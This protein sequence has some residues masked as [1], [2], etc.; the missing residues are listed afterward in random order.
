MIPV[1]LDAQV[2]YIVHALR[3]M[4][5]KGLAPIEPTRWAFDAWDAYTQRQAARSVVTTTS[6]YYT[7]KSGKVVTEWIG[8]STEYIAWSTA[9]SRLGRFVT[10]SRGRRQGRMSRVSP[11]HDAEASGDGVGTNGA[12]GLQVR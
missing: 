1:A 11:A 8:S 4:R 5:R 7:S 6:D 12:E 9:L 2:R 10:R 3:R